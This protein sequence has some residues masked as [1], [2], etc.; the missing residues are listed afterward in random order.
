MVDDAGTQWADK[1]SHGRGWLPDDGAMV[2]EVAMGSEHAGA[3]TGVAEGAGGEE[4]LQDT[5]G[6]GNNVQAAEPESPIQAAFLL[7]ASS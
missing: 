1:D 4:E 2:P 5:V 3:A 7:M 6:A